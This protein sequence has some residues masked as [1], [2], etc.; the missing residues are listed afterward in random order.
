[1]PRQN[2][3]RATDARL[4]RPANHFVERTYSGNLLD[5][6]MSRPAVSV[7]SHTYY[8]GSL[9]WHLRSDGSRP[10]RMSGSAV[11]PPPESVR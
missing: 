9:V 4:Q 11:T 2:R 6:P 8:Q 10:N 1:M 7:S 3:G 5:G